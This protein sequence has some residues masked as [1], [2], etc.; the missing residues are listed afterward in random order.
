MIAPQAGPAAAASRSAP[1]PAAPRT[2]TPPPHKHQPETRITINAAAARRRA[3]DRAVA[4]D[5]VV[6]PGPG[7]RGGRP[8][9]SGA[10]GKGRRRRPARRAPWRGADGSEERGG[11]RIGGRLSLWSGG[12]AAQRRE[13]G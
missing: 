7:G 3:A 10:A 6:V 9:R 12:V 11:G 13:R 2:V 1:R 5:R 8:A 4:M